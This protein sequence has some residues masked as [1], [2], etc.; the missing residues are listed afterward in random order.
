MKGKNFV[1]WIVLFSLQAGAFAGVGEYFN[2]FYCNYLSERN[3]RCE[4]REILNLLQKISY[5]KIVDI[6]NYLKSAKTME[7]KRHAIAL[8]EEEYL[9]FLEN[10]NFELNYVPNCPMTK[11]GIKKIKKAHKKYMR[12][13]EK[14]YLF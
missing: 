11:R 9:D 2:S 5:K 6:E 13:L 10:I 7:E 12:Q 4:D 14:C 3:V 8:I 1:L